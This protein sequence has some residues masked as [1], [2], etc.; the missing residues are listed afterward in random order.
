MKRKKTAE[1]FE[2]ER[3]SKRR[4]LSF[5][6]TIDLEIEK[7]EQERK[8]TKKLLRHYDLKISKIYRKF[9]MLTNSELFKMKRD[10]RQQEIYNTKLEERKRKL[11]ILREDIFYS[12]KLR[13][14]KGSRRKA[15]KIYDDQINEFGELRMKRHNLISQ[16]P[17]NENLSINENDKIVKE[18]K[19]THG[20]IDIENNRSYC[21]NILVLNYRHFIPKKYFIDSGLF[22][23][24][25]QNYHKKLKEIIKDDFIIKIHYSNLCINFKRR[26]IYMIYL[27]K[28]EIPDFISV[29]ITSLRS[30]DDIQH[31]LSEFREHFVKKLI[32]RYPRIYDWPTDVT[33][34]LKW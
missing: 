2:D 24:N 15:L 30:I 16:I 11:K 5:R 26:F 4:K 20:I 29:D 27:P 31:A 34:L 32:L 23:F 10:P 18:L 19:Q 21:D 7:K 3:N 13:K 12:M 14:L 33:I 9:G 8:Q 25:N 6:Y 28:D 17:Y 1:D 22:D